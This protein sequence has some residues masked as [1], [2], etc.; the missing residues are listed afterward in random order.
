M[1]GVKNLPN[2]RVRIYQDEILKVITRSV[3]NLERG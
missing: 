3:V 2:V 1:E